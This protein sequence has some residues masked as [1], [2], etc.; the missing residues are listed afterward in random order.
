MIPASG[1]AISA[2]SGPIHR[3]QSS[4][5]SARVQMRRTASACPRSLGATGGR[6]PVHTLAVLLLGD[7]QALVLEHLQRGIDDA[8]A[9][10]RD[11][12][13]KHRVGNPREQALSRPCA[14]KDAGG[15]KEKEDGREDAADAEPGNRGDA[16][17][18]GSASYFS[19]R[20]VRSTRTGTSF[21]TGMVSSDGGS[22]L[23][24]ESVAGIVP[25]SRV[26]SPCVC[27]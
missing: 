14:G 12:P 17:A 5:C 9:D 22:I 24:S 1:P 25:D 6:Q 16:A 8:R 10:R 2:A 21:F 18:A 20:H 7:H 27:S 3:D 19:F 26:W 13:A 4:Q 23:K 11:D 15:A